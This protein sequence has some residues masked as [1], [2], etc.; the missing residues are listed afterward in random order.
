MGS[1]TKRTEEFHR[2]ELQL[3]NYAAIYG[4]RH[5]ECNKQKQRQQREA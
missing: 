4:R 3:Q 1:G 5:V 2:N